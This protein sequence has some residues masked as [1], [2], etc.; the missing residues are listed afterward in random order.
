MSWGE[1]GLQL[2]VTV[3]GVALAGGITALLLRHE[4]STHRTAASRND[5]VQAGADLVAAALATFAASEVVESLRGPQGPGPAVAATTSLTTAVAEVVRH[6]EPLRYHDDIGIRDEADAMKMAALG[7]AGAFGGRQILF[8]F[9]GRHRR[10]ERARRHLEQ[11]IRDV[12][13]EVDRYAT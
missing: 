10:L 13:A 8:W 6:A 3:V 9:P 5:A 11:S 1:F 7:V 4:L 12:R 2:V